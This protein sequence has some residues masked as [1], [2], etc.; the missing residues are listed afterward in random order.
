[1]IQLN[2][3]NIAR[4]LASNS[5]RGRVTFYQDSDGSYFS[6]PV[7]P[8]LIDK[9]LAEFLS[10]DDFVRSALEKITSEAK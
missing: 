6:L 9:I 8:E 1:M 4:G 10:Y 2:E 7:P 3:L 5:F